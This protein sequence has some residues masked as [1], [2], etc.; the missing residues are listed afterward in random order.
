MT[1]QAFAIFCF[2]GFLIPVPILA[3]LD[4]APGPPKRS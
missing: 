2:L 1:S 4:R 3:W